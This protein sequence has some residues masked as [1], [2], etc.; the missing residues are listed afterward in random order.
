MCVYVYICIK[1]IIIIIISKSSNEL[2]QLHK[3]SLGQM[4]A[5]HFSINC[6]I[7]ADR[8]EW[9]LMGL[10]VWLTK[11]LPQ[12]LVTIIASNGIQYNT[13]LP[14]SF[15]LFPS[16][17]SSM[18]LPEHS[19]AWT[20][21]ITAKWRMYGWVW[22]FCKHQVCVLSLS[23]VFLWRLG[24]QRMLITGY[25]VSIVRQFF[26]AMARVLCWILHNHIN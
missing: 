5:F 7:I 8:C 6:R 22:L 13:S 23:F 17:L 3:S 16:P 4:H 11:A 12:I 25:C 24:K 15:P 10:S 19:D 26:F 21:T 1:L 20:T 18:L 2:I 9:D 14:H